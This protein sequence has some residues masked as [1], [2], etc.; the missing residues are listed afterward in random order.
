MPER[1]L[2][3]LHCTCPMRIRYRTK[4]GLSDRSIVNV[5][6]GVVTQRVRVLDTE[7]HEE[8]VRMLAIDDRLAIG[9]LSCLKQKRI[10]AV[11]DCRR[12]KTEH[13]PEHDASG[14]QAMNCAQHPPIR[15]IEPVTRA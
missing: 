14:A 6:Y 13:G 12:L 4:G 11:R 1:R 10:P 3:E 5:P 8:I 7:V 2:G 15:R 9:R